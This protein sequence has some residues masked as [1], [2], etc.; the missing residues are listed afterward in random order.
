MEGYT[1][2][3]REEIAFDDAILRYTEMHASA[4]HGKQTIIN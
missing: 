1:E 3:H 2:V 4:M